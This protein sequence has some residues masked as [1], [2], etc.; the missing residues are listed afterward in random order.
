MN[1]PQLT[2]PAT[3]TVLLAIWVTAVDPLHCTT[4]PFCLGVAVNVIVEVIS[5]TG[6]LNT[7]IK[8]AVFVR[9]AI[10][11][12]LSKVARNNE[13]NTGNN[14][15]SPV[16]LRLLLF[17]G[18]PLAVDPLHCTT[19]PFRLAVAVMVRVEVISVTL[20]FITVMGLAVFVK[21]AT[22][23]MLSHCGGETP[24]QSTRLPR[25]VLPSTN[26]IRVLPEM[27]G[28]TIQSRPIPCM[29]VQV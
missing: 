22:K 8:L 3:L 29:T 24:L 16:I 19:L 4:V 11:L 15:E 18:F 7:V 13:P 20:V 14:M 9:V 6:I 2:L 17:I 25:G 5:A 27:N 23:S 12:M 10:K 21:V 28:S 26:R 1:Q